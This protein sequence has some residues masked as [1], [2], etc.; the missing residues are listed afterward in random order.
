VKERH[1][2][3]ARQKEAGLLAAFDAPAK[4]SAA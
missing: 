4:Q 3:A 1:L 2:K